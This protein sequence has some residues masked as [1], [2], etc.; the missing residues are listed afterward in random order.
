MKIIP[1]EVREG[2]IEVVLV[3]D[4]EIRVPIAATYTDN[5]SV[6]AKVDWTKLKEEIGHFKSKFIKHIVKLIETNKKEKT[7][8][9]AFYNDKLTEFSAKRILGILKMPEKSKSQVS[10]LLNKLKYANIIQGIEHGRKVTYQLT[11][12][13]SEVC[14]KLFGEEQ[15]F[16]YS[17]KSLEEAIK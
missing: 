17:N 12:F 15:T 4:K 8:L 13:G 1:F 16:D 14:D 6:L 2:K 3:G 5:L 11:E 9:N 10:I 7:L